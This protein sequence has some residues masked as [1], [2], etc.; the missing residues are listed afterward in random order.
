[1]LSS[2]VVPEVITDFLLHFTIG[3]S[4]TSQFGWGYGPIH[5]SNFHCSGVEATLL[6]C[7]HSNSSSAC[8]HNLDASVICR[9]TKVMAIVY[10]K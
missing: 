6:D 1:M 5:F 8:G 9:G 10:K 3:T 4:S 7:V 2:N